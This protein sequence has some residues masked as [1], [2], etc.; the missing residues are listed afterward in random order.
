M[1]TRQAPNVTFSKFA[2]R[3]SVAKS[4]AAVNRFIITAHKGGSGPTPA[5]LDLVRMN[6]ASKK[7][8]IKTQ[9]D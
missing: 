1:A 9:T 7:S 4:T 6:L 8:R 3:A 2:C 5:L